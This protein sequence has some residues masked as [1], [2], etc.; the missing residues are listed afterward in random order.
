MIINILNGLALLQ[1]WCE[2]A[3]TENLNDARGKKRLSSTCSKTVRHGI[4][5]HAFSST[6]DLHRIP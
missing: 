2:K 5:K 6:D 1:T 3:G 4:P